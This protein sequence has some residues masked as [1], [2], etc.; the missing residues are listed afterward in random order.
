ML[1]VWEKQEMHTESWSEA[2]ENVHTKDHAA[3]MAFNQT[4]KWKGLAQ[5]HVQFRDSTGGA[6]PWRWDTILLLSLTKN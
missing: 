6:E 1:L 2:L 3:V 5:D 4:R